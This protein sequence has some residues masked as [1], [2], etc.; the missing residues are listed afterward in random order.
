MEMQYKEIE[1]VDI[2]GLKHLQCRAVVKDGK[3]T[4]EFHLKMKNRGVVAPDLL[5]SI[6][7]GILDNVELGIIGLDYDIYIMS[8]SAMITSIM[9]EMLQKVDE[10]I[11]RNHNV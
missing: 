3:Q 9:D 6:A 11:E 10:Y 8:K 1:Y 5:C 7:A 4:G 2:K